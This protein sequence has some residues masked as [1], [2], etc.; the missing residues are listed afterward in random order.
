[1]LR[2]GQ[3]GPENFSVAP[4]AQNAKLRALTK[5]EISAPLNGGFAGFTEE[6]QWPK[7]KS[8]LSARC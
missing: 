6:K 4:S 7:A 2:H 5:A 1:M 8:M 3:L